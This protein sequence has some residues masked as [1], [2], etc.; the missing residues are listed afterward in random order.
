LSQCTT[1]L[2]LAALNRDSELNLSLPSISGQRHC[3]RVC[4]AKSKGPRSCP[5][6]K[7]RINAA[8]KVLHKVDVAL[9]ELSSPSHKPSPQLSNPSPSPVRNPSTHLLASSSHAQ[10]NILTAFA[11]LRNDQPIFDRYD[12]HQYSRRHKVKH[13]AGTLAEESFKNARTAV[14]SDNTVSRVKQLPKI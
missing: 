12:N 3:S 14:K 7:P 13:P 4:L 11:S 2:P 10:D 6:W 9:R 8:T 1:I 5:N